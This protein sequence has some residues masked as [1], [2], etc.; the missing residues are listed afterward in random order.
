MLTWVSIYWFARAGLAASL[1][2]Y[3]EAACPGDWDLATQ[4]LARGGDVKVG[5]SRFPKDLVVVPRTWVRV[6][7]GGHVMFQRDHAA[8]GHF[9]AH[10][11]PRELV[12][13][14]G[15][16]F[17]WGGPAYGVVRGNTGYGE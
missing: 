11:M 3:Y 13:D 6:L 4:R 12:A 17:G 2:I 8:G 7:G 14:L 1:R 5:V 10:E 15:A 9:A 16:M